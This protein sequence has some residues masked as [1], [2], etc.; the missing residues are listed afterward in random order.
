MA[1]LSEVDL[2]AIL[3][4][5]FREVQKEA[6]H[7][8]GVKDEE[9]LVRERI[10]NREGHVFNAYAILFIGAALLFSAYYTATGMTF[11]IQ[12]GV[13]FAFIAVGLALLFYMKTQ[14]KQLLAR[15]DAMQVNRTP[16]G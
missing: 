8:S 12:T 2:E 14:L 15:R 3:G 16:A 9:R 7:K 11:A 4:S 5:N 6:A 1:A 13:G 10:E